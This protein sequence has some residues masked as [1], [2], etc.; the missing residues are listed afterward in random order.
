[1]NNATANVSMFAVILA[2]VDGSERSPGVVRAASAIARQGMGRVH[3]YRSVTIPQEFPAAARMPPDKLPAILMEHAR[4][5]L[6]ALASD[7]SDIVIEEPAMNDPPQAW[8]SILKEADRLDADLIVI[9]SHGFGGWDHVL[10]TTAAKVVNHAHR[11]VLVVHE[12]QL[13]PEMPRI[14]L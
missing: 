7:Y 13:M 1:M 12:R 4:R 10:G 5:D 6:E 11:N 14:D 3:L 2:A 8:R 9:G